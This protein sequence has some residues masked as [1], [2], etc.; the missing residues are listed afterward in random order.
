MMK[1]ILISHTGKGKELSDLLRRELDVPDNCVQFTVTFELD[2]P[3][4]VSCTYMPSEPGV[5][6][7]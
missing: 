1:T 2:A 4:L 3:V 5:P 7:E 6:K